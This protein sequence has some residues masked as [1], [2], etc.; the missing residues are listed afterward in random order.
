MADPLT[1]R[2]PAMTGTTG[3]APNTERRR[4][5]PD[6]SEEV[7][8]STEAE[9]DAQFAHFQRLWTAVVS[10]GVVAVTAALLRSCG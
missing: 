6:A 10:V 8:E 9:A 2:R 1:P 5:P 7:R 4:R 3:T